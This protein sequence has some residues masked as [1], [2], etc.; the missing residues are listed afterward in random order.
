[1]PSPEITQLRSIVEKAGDKELLELIDTMIEERKNSISGAPAVSMRPIYRKTYHPS[2]V[3]RELIALVLDRFRENGYMMSPLPPIYLSSETP[4]IFIAFPELEDEYEN[5][6]PFDLREIIDKKWGE[7]E[8]SNRKREEVS[9]EKRRLPYSNNQGEIV[10]IEEALGLYIPTAPQIILY[11]RGID[12][13]S[14]RY[15]LDENILRAVVLVHE[16]GHWI[17]HLLPKPEVPAW[18]TDLFTLTSMD[19]T[20]GW[21]QLITQWVADEI[22]GGFARTFEELNRHQTPPY[23]TYK[24]FTKVPLKLIISSLELLRQLRWPA[25]LSDWENFVMS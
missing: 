8:E 20:E 21:A 10:T 18:P 25:R 19:V 4:P 5:R 16:I 7:A 12:W 11:Q 24:E 22:S 6:E 17:T 9:R 2:R 13:F 15:R 1:M 3:E 23:H 14:K